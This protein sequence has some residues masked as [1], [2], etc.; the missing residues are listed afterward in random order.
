MNEKINTILSYI[1]DNITEKIN[2]EALVKNSF[3]SAIQIYRMFI[4]TMNTT[5]MHY[6]KQR[7]LYFAAK[8]L[9][10]E[11]SKIAVIAYKYG[12][13]SHDVFIRAFK[14]FYGATPSEFIKNG[15]DLNDFYRLNSYCISNFS[16]NFT[17]NNNEENCNMENWEVHEVQIVTFPETKLI[18]IL[19]KSDDEESAYDMF[20][21]LY[22]RV[23]RNAPN[24]IYPN[25]TNATHAV[26]IVL[27]NG[28]CDYFIG[29]E[30]S[31]FDNV[32]PDALM[33]TLQTQKSAFIGYIGGLDYREITD[34]FYDV[35]LEKT[36][37]KS[38][39]TDKY[40]YCTVE[41]YSPN[42]DTGNYEERIYIPIEE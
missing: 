34:Y 8:E 32:P 27:K 40:P 41:Y 5:P 19:H 21:N 23:F 28:K 2:M 31:S 30:V 37:Y 36:N 6:V 9:V 22:D 20:Y 10:G 4:N 29:I 24:R 17:L 33:L 25:S 3:Y 35:W 18:G 14:R 39:V 42:N 26:S 13:E 15:N 7:K 11:S 1:D 38:A 16:L 12:F